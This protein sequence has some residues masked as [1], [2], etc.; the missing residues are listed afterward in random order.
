M[1]LRI[2]LADD[3]P[4]VGAAVRDQLQ[5]QPGWVVCGM[6]TSATELLSSVEALRP[7]I[8]I[9]DYHMPGPRD[10]DGIRLISTLRRHH[11]SVSVIV[12][13][14]ITNPMILRSILK[15]RV[16]GLVLKD[17]PLS[18]LITVVARIQ[19]GFHYIGKSALDILAQTNLDSPLEPGQ[20]VAQRLSV[21]ETEVIRLYLSGRS[22]SEIAAILCRSVKTISR[23]KNCAMQKLGASNDRELFECAARQGILLP[24]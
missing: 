1:T 19:R 18:E 16:H 22:V 15:A 12:L 2:L 14:M 11:P 9:T 23:Q 8:V 3:H 20:Q 5:T 24:T 7:D 17:A 21:R 10:P 13:T 6:V 4:V